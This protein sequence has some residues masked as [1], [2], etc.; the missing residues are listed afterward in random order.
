M[1]CSKIL[2]ALVL[3]FLIVAQ[4]ATKKIQ[5]NRMTKRFDVKTYARN[6]GL[7]MLVTVVG[8]GNGQAMEKCLDLKGTPMGT[9][10]TSAADPSD[11]YKTS[12]D[13]L[14]TII[15]VG[16]VALNLACAFKDMILAFVNSRRH[17]V[18]LASSKIKKVNKFFFKNY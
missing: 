12:L 7:G 6:F 13:W 14:D 18:F 2:L 1:K 11:N 9:D 17:R 4:A 3:V 5:S 16:K 10:T 8:S 15:K